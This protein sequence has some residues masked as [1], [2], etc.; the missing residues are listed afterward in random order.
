MPT[1]YQHPAVLTREE[2]WEQ[3]RSM[4]LSKLDATFGPDSP[5]ISGLGSPARRPVPEAATLASLAPGV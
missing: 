4:P 1:G 3:V 5:P 2:L